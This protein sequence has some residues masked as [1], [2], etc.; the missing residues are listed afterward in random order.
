MERCLFQMI[1]VEIRKLIIRDDE[2]DLHFTTEKR[3]PVHAFVTRGSGKFYRTLLE[4]LRR[5]NVKYIGEN[6]I[7]TSQRTGHTRCKK[8][9]PPTSAAP[10]HIGLECFV[11]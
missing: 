11:F 7:L 2:I 1:S 8:S 5:V 10:K 9:S 3:V 4:K 6:A